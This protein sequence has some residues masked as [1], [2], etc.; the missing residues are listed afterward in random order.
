MIS[1]TRRS[2]AGLTTLGVIA[3][4]ALILSGYVR[5][6]GPP[7]VMRGSLGMKDSTAPA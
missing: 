5:S 6:A 1:S 4:T 7:I 3:G 2:F